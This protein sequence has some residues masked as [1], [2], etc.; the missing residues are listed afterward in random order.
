MTGP[1]LR[2][3]GLKKHFPVRKGLFGRAQG[4]VKAVDGVSLEVAAGKT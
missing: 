1:L 2:A 3:V 4:A